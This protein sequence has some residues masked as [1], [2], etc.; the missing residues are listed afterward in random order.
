MT[1]PSNSMLDEAKAFYDREFTGDAYTPV[2]SHAGGYAQLE[3]FVFEHQLVQGA[4]CLEVGCGRGVFQD[5]VAD[6]T[7][8]DLAASVARY[9]HKPFVQASATAL[10][11]PDSSF[12]AAW[13]IWV[14]EH[15]PDPELAMAELRRVLKPG[16]LLFFA[17]AWQCRPWA[18]D[19]Y[20]V[21]PYSDFNLKG[22]LYKATIPLRD[23]IAWRSFFTIPRRL[24]RLVTRKLH[25]GP[26]PFRYKKLRGNFEKFWMSD[27]D[28]IN[29]MDAYEALVWF[30]S[31]GDQVL[32]P[33]GFAR[34]FLI[35]NGHILVR[36][37]K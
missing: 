21:R 37:R 11:F 24:R 13:T 5:L 31:R 35:R 7:G 10:P 16:G 3:R 18:A 32:H 19:G 22:K 36:I 6:Y 30:Q 23:S 15:V 26:T 28:A 1:T 2:E 27:S 20:P 17:P 12:D 34:Q 29:A 33:T 8:V 4:R 9:L 25:P 14:F